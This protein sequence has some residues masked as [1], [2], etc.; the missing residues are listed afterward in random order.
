MD[1]LI[2]TKIFFMYLQKNKNSISLS[3]LHRYKF[4]LCHKQKKQFWPI[5]LGVRSQLQLTYQVSLRQNYYKLLKFIKF[6]LFQYLISFNY[7]RHLSITTKLNS[8]YLNKRFTE[9]TC[10]FVY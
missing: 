7:I 10:M 9:A 8:D 1:I 3:K 5:K 6:K 2:R 4:F